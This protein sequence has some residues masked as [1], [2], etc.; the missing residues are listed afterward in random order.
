MVYIG[1]QQVRKKMS[2][3]KCLGKIAET[4]RG[5]IVGAVQLKA[6]KRGLQTTIGV[7]RCGH[8]VEG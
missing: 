5:L 1:M 7:S 8:R 3:N 6:S 2:K 4:S